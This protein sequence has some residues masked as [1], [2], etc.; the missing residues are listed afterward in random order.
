M[1]RLRSSL[2][3]AAACAAAATPALAGT[4]PGNGLYEHTADYC[5]IGGEP[6]D[7]P[8]M[9]LTGGSTFWMGDVHYAVAKVTWTGPDWTQTHVYGAKKGL[10]GPAIDCYGTIDGVDIHST[11]VPIR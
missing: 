2:V 3:L 5:V 1:P 8:T 11:D 10:P 9:Y 7:A 6:F 4:P